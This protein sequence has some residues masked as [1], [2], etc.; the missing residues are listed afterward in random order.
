[1][2]PSSYTADG[3][4]GFQYLDG[5]DLYDIHQDAHGPLLGDPGL[6]FS[7]LAYLM[8]MPY[9]LFTELDLPAPI[10]EPISPTTSSTTSHTSTVVI[11]HP[12]HSF[13]TRTRTSK[14]HPCCWCGKLY[15]RPG[16]AEGCENRHQNLR[17]YRCEKGCGDPNW[18]FIYS[19]LGWTVTDIFAQV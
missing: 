14:V 15:T 3:L 8:S 13:S 4:N 7:D 5:G 10:T 2:D 6:T 17:P 12:N 11:N 19:S 9:H 1:M 18:Y 16:L